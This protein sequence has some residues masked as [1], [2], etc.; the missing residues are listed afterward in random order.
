M[1]PMNWLPW[2][3]IAIAAAA[4][5]GL[6]VRFALMYRDMKREK[7]QRKNAADE[8]ATLSI[9]GEFFVMSAL[10][11]YEVGEGKQLK[12]GDYVV[13]TDE[14]A[15]VMINGIVA[16]YSDGETL[17]L[18]DGDAI[19]AEKDLRVKPQKEQ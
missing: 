17:T 7:L 3:L 18:R 15:S 16:D 13:R 6:V 14:V 2:L 9:D 5:I 4:L 11:L 19:R 1:D 8:Q 10:K 12:S